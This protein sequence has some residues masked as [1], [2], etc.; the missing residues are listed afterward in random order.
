MTLAR[1]C[2][3]ARREPG[4]LEGPVAALARLDAQGK[5]HHIETLRAFLD[6][7]GDVASAAKS[8]GV[9]PNTFRF[10]MR[11]LVEV[12]GLDLDDPDERLVFHLQLRIRRS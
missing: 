2:E 9:H 8:I 3:I 5:S 11:R 12:S 6:T 4:L 1:L 10:R 7:F